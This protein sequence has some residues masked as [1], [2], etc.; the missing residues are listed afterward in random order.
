MTTSTP[1]RGLLRRLPALSVAAVAALAVAGAPAAAQD[2]EM[3]LVLEVSG[4]SLPGQNRLHTV[5]DGTV[6]YGTVRLTGGTTI[7]GTDVDVEILG[8]A[9]Y[10]GGNGPFTGTM[11]IRYPSGD[12]LGLRYDSVLLADGD[13]THIIGVVDVLGGTGVLAGLDGTGSVDAR[14]S[15]PLGSALTYTLTLDVPGIP[16]PADSP[17]TPTS[18]LTD[19]DAAALDLMTIYSDMLVAK[20]RDGLDA[21]LSDAFV[22]QRTDGSHATKDEYLANLPDLTSFA[23]EEPSEA[24]AGDVVTL[25]M[26]AQAELVIDGQPYR[27][28]P[29]P[30]LA[31]FQWSGPGWQLVAQGNF[32]LP[33]E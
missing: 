22:I 10:V 13:E 1:R 6:L 11:T 32:N 23:F 17:A 12:E 26:L 29:A 24:R 15:G 4:V 3:P 28:E 16:D 33:R 9:R 2:L 30:M 25:R 5:A 18:A 21:L 31:V 14:R 27:P 8:T 20:D 7:N 19:P